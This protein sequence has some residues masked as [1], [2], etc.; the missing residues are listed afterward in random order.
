MKKFFFIFLS[1][2]VFLFFFIFFLVKYFSLKIEKPPYYIFNTISQAFNNNEYKDKPVANF[3][4]LGLDKR[5]DRLEKTE[6]TDTIIF[7]SL[8]SKTN[9]LNTISL[10]R[11]LW[12]YRLNSKINNVYPAS[13]E[14]SDSFGFIKNNFQ[15]ILGQPVD[16]VIVI[17]TEDL[18]NFVQVIGGVDVYLDKGFV[19]KQYPNPDYINN[20]KA[21]IYK[22]IEF[23]AGLNHLS[24]SNITEYVR[25]RKSADTVEAGGTDLGRIKRQQILI[26]AIL[27]KIKSKDFLL[28]I[29]NDINLYNFWSQSIETTLTDKDILSMT[30]SYKN[31]LKNISINRIEIPIGTTAKDGLIYHPLTFIN[32][33]WVFIPQDK[34]YKSLHDFIRSQFS[35]I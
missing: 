6:T 35:D 1:S 23:P 3:L 10:P 34:D 13:L 20:P 7:A 19:D 33:Q 31:S 16:D 2:I 28:N 9:K 5:D 8:N 11:D 22:T 25:S 27:S 32:R 17:T 26:E 29:K 4:I 30:L 18:I 14:V 24:K 15:D 21:P 12:S